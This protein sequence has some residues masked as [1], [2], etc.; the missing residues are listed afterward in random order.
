[1]QSRE[2]QK[3]TDSGSGKLVSNFK[4]S[5]LQMFAMSVTVEVVQE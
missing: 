1:M 3:P 2:H 5:E 4:N